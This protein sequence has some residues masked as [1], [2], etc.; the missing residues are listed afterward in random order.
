MS[1]L[2]IADSQCLQNCDV[3]VMVHE[4]H[5]VR[6]VEGRNGKGWMG[7]KWLMRA[8]W[9]LRGMIVGC[10]LLGRSGYGLQVQGAGLL[11]GV[12]TI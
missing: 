6:T 2:L 11:L 8:G 5:P 4:P 10:G 1:H 7:A 12:R 9:R 3:G